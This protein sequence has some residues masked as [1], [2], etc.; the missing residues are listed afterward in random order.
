MLLGWF[1]LLLLLLGDVGRVIIAVVLIGRRDITQLK[2]MHLERPPLDRRREAPWRRAP[3]FGP[4]A[5]ATLGH[6]D[7]DILENGG[8]RF[9][10]TASDFERK[11][12][13][14]RKLGS[15]VERQSDRFV[16]AKHFDQAVR[17]NIL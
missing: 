4:E 13:C 10:R 1:G 12:L 17:A 6:P 2:A 3:A 5:V 15:K 14:V 8:E 9:G 16:L 7:V 11:F